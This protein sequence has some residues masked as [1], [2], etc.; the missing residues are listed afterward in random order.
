ML[1]LVLSLYS[2]YVSSEGIHW[3]K[4]IKPLIISC[5]PIPENKEYFYIRVSVWYMMC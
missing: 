1:I 3:N 4:H 5:Q 2:V